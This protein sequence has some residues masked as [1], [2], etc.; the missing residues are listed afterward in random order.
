MKARKR[1]FDLF[2]MIVIKSYR[3]E[4]KILK[5]FEKYQKKRIFN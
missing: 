1:I 3:R 2:L 4:E 5:R